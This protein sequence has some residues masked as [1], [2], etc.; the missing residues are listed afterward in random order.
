M[1][2]AIY[3]AKSDFDGKFTEFC[4][5]ESIVAIPSLSDYAWYLPEYNPE[6]L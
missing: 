5:L 1:S 2:D 3:K 4:D 6:S